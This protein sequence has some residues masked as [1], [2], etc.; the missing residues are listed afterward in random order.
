MN[1]EQKLFACIVGLLKIAPCVCFR[2]MVGEWPDDGSRA[3]DCECV[4]CTAFYTLISIG[5]LSE[6]G[7]LLDGRFEKHYQP[8]GRD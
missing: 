6:D 4:T 2:V 1:V 8:E 5:I 3:P 7:E